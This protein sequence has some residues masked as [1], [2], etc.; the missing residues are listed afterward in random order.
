V[1]NVGN[2]HTIGFLVFKGRIRGIF[3]HHT[4]LLSPELLWRD[5]ARFRSGEL[6]NDDV[7]QAQGHGCTM[8][9]T[10]AHAGGYPLIVALGPRRAMLS[11]FDV[12]FPAPGGDMMLAGC[13]GLIKGW[14]LMQEREPIRETAV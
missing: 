1:V 12:Q 13:F 10:P 4:G 3:E 6:S 8:V 11:G 14:K 2:S 5:L 9:G 7:F